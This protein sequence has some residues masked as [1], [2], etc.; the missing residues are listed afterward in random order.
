MPP[1]RSLNTKS[2]KAKTKRPRLTLSAPNIENNSNRTRLTPSARVKLTPNTQNNSN[3]TANNKS[4]PK[5]T[6]INIPENNKKS[7]S[8]SNKIELTNPATG[9]AVLMETLTQTTSKMSNNK[10]QTV[11]KTSVSI[12]SLDGPQNQV[13]TYKVNINKLKNHF[14]NLEDVNRWETFVSMIG[15]FLFIIALIE[16]ETKCYYPIDPTDKTAVVIRLK[17]FVE[18]SMSF[19][20]FS[21][22][23]LADSLNIGLYAAK[24][25]PDIFGYHVI[26]SFATEQTDLGAAYCKRI[27]KKM[28]NDGVVAGISEVVKTAFGQIVF[29][30]A[31]LGGTIYAIPELVKYVPD[32]FKQLA[33]GDGGLGQIF[34]KDA[35]AIRKLQSN[36]EQKRNPK[37]KPYDKFHSRNGDF[38]SLMLGFTEDLLANKILS[39]VMKIPD[40]VTGKKIPLNKVKYGLR[41][42][43]QVA[44]TAKMRAD[45]NFPFLNTLQ[46]TLTI[47]GTILS[48]RYRPIAN[49]L[50]RLS[51]Q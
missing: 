21:P 12:G 39:V 40:L 22:K 3:R 6:V 35:S 18:Y 43:L 14:S 28:R 31:A 32:T 27:S 45:P 46:T 34:T 44:Q 23:Q 4:S 49:G 8:N 25:L 11:I 42:T 9:E 15:D 41:K 33:I 17:E 48:N 26:L 30:S 2:S 37:Q 7:N 29:L 5:N 24:M 38:M 36:A 51:R 10:K 50:K 1:K 19:L 20:G 16:L 47:P 13:I